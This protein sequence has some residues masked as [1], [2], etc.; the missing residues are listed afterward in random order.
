MSAPSQYRHTHTHT[1]THTYIYIY[2]CA[3]ARTRRRA[4][5]H[6]HTHTPARTHSRAY[7]RTHA[8][9][10]APGGSWKCY[11]SDTK[12][13]WVLSC[14]LKED[15]V[16][17]CLTEKG[18]TGICQ[19]VYTFCAIKCHRCGTRLHFR[20]ML[21]VGQMDEMLNDQTSTTRQF[22]EATNVQNCRSETM[23]KIVK[24]IKKC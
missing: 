2:I 3:H 21:T 9:T 5:P 7:P 13:G 18:T 10:R 11:E 1:H 14:D 4:H 22:V 20:W 23:S 12:K 17:T 24:A 8:R 19:E 6:T 15:K 16:W